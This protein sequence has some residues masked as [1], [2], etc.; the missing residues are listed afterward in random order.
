MLRCNPHG[1]ALRHTVWSLSIPL[2]LS[3][4]PFPLS[5]PG[6]VCPPVAQVPTDDSPTHLFGL[7]L[8]LACRHSPCTCRRDKWRG[9]GV[10]G[11]M[12]SL[13]C[14]LS[15]VWCVLCAVCVSGD[16]ETMLAC[17]SVCFR[18]QCKHLVLLSQ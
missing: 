5:L 6:S 17:W 16:V 13:C 1:V 9:T 15:V 14:V 7:K 18:V 2:S 11:M 12:C 10:V 3:L 8:T 4:P